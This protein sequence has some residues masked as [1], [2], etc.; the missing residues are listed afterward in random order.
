VQPLLVA[1]GIKADTVG[2]R[3]KGTQIV[4]E[5]LSTSGDDLRG[6]S[7]NP[8]AATDAATGYFPQAS[9]FE[10]GGSRGSNYVHLSGS[11]S[12][13]QRDD[14]VDMG[15]NGGET[16]IPRELP[17]NTATTA[18]TA[19]SGQ[20]GLKGKH[21]EARTSRSETLQNATRGPDER[22]RT[23]LSDEDELEYLDG[24]VGA[25]NGVRRV[26]LEEREVVRHWIGRDLQS[27]QTE[28]DATR[29]A[30]HARALMLARFAMKGEPLPRTHAIE[31]I[32]ATY[33]ADQLGLHMAANGLAKAEGPIGLDLETTALDPKDGLIRLVQLSRGGHTY[34]IDAFYVDAKPLLNALY[35]SSTR[36]TQE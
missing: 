26:T 30:A 8:A 3:R 13:H 31:G 14:G 12:H 33:V 36:P 32:N 2:S 9:G 4:L 5:K 22:T 19:T 11:L 18:T 23:K 17:T 15:E 25:C 6:G 16:H 29:N 10:N 27:W 28:F 35:A 7:T 20:N 21:R 1:M 24:F 34:V